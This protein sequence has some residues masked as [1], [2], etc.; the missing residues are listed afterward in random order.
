MLYEENEEGLGSHLILRLKLASELISSFAWHPVIIPFMILHEFALYGFLIEHLFCE[1][2]DH[3]LL[4]LRVV[5]EVKLNFFG[6]CSRLQLV[7]L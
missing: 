7:I 5:L 6:E 1:T 2:V 4:S 3:I